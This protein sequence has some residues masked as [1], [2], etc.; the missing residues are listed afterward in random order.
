MSVCVYVYECVCVCVYRDYSTLF[1]H[2]I[3]IQH[4]ILFNDQ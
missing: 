4:A 3:L 1:I 2:L